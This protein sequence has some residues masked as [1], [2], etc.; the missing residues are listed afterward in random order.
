[1]KKLL[2]AL[3]LMTTANAHG[4]YSEPYSTLDETALK[5]V[6]DFIPPD[7]KA[8]ALAQGD[9]NKDGQTDYALVIQDTNEANI[10]SSGGL[11]DEKID[12]NPRSLLVLFSN[13]GAEDDSAEKLS[14]K[15]IYRRFIP[16]L[17]PQLP[18]MAEPFSYIGINEGDLEVKFEVWATSGS[19]EKDHLTY[20]FRYQ[21]KMDDFKLI[22]FDHR[23]VHRATGMFKD[24]TIDL[25]KKKM[26]KAAGSMSSP[27][28]KKETLAF[29]A[30]QDWTPCSI[31]EPLV[32]YP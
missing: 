2:T 16:S 7:W 31:K 24:V 1:M 5:M 3:L 17:N 14:R 25:V 4:D 23:N 19:W 8:I 15:R 9:L 11:I 6:D 10:K 28:H 32:F 12:A 29:V 27:M 21:K 26:D 13:P 18:E 22:V 20:R 30:A